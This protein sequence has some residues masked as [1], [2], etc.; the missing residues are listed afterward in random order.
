MTYTRA[1]GSY[2]VARENFGPRVAQ[3]AAAALLI[4]YVVTVAV[5]A[6]AGT[7]AVVSA[8]PALGPYSLAITVGVVLFICY[9]NLRGLR[10]AGIHFA[11]ATY[12]FVV[13]IG[14]MI[15]V[16]VVRVIFGDYRYTT[17]AQLPGTVPVHQGNGLVMGATILVLLRAFANGGSSLT[18]VEAISNTVDLF[19]KPQ[20]LNARRVLIAMACILGFLLAGVGLPR[21]CH[22]RHAV[23]RRLSVD[24]VGGGPGGL[25]PRDVRQRLL[26]PRPGLD[27]RHLVHRSEHQLQRF[28]RVGQFRRR[29]PLP[30]AAV[31]ETRL[32]PGVLQRHHRAHGALGG[33][34]GRDRR[35]GQRAGPV[36]RDRRVHRLLDGRLRNV[37]TPSDAPRTRMATPAGDQPLR[38]NPVDGRGRHLRGGEV[39]RGRMAGSRCLPGAGVRADTAQQ[40]ISSRG[41]HSRDVPHRPPRLGEVRAAPGARVRELG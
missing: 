24:A 29:R 34:V 35:L 28:P 31:D 1:G 21:P 27:R 41:R 15:V 40:G 2:I 11:V 4:D 19:R 18:G 26:H 10:E 13:M 5:Q 25:R 7:V 17:R 20:G 36:L 38:G 33:V 6:A 3:V 30:A 39:H 9:A 32:S 16:G 8:I 22:P 14:L 23:C 37:Q 12:S